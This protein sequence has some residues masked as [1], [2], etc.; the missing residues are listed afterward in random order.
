M[1]ESF[2]IEMKLAE[3]LNELLAIFQKYAGEDGVLDK[4]Q[5]KTLTTTELAEINSRESGSALI[6]IFNEEFATIDENEDGKVSFSE[7]VEH[8]TILVN[9]A[10]AAE[11]DS[12]DHDA[13]RA[14]RDSPWRTHRG[15]REPSREYK[16]NKEINRKMS[17]AW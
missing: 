9:T 5:L 1:G 10:A 14:Y 16:E 6:T 4:D 17:E 15:G 7:F 8:M 11:S 2:F 12:S 3:L 13:A